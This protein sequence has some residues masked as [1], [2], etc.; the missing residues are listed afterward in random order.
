MNDFQ[1]KYL[2]YK[3]KYIQL[4]NN[5]EGGRRRLTS[6]E[7][8]L[9]IELKKENKM[10][11][12]IRKLCKE[13]NYDCEDENTLIYYKLLLD[14]NRKL[15]YYKTKSKNYS[16][17]HDLLMNLWV[18]FTK[19]KHNYDICSEKNKLTSSFM[20]KN[21]KTFSEYINL[22]KNK[23]KDEDMLSIYNDVI[24]IEKYFFKVQM[25]LEESKKKLQ[26]KK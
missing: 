19:L 13:N 7:K 20:C 3:N 26:F 15:D 14:Y 24:Y 16:K 11:K 4:K 10:I 2:K 9:N 25:A 8:Y 5:I 22:E 1:Q 6:H 18:S 23:I 12:D 21:P 17:A